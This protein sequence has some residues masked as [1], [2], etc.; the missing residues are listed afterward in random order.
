MAE[1][2]PQSGDGSPQ[3]IDDA[4]RSTLHRMS[5]HAGIAG[6]PAPVE[7]IRSRGTRRRERRIVGTATLGGAVVLTMVTFAV[8]SLAG[9]QRTPELSRPTIEV[10]R[11]P[12]P[13][14]TIGV[15]MLPKGCCSEAGA[16]TVGEASLFGS[17]APCAS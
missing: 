4:L 5:A 12:Y 8:T 2:D 16:C 14:V 11:R 6:R 7:Q 10:S 1:F 9:F 13:N 15:L 3:Q 17:G